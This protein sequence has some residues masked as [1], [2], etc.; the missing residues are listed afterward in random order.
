[1]QERKERGGRT[2]A[3]TSLAIG[4]G[5]ST[6]RRCGFSSFV[7]NRLLVRCGR[8]AETVEKFVELAH[9]GAAGR[10]LRCGRLRFSLPFLR[11]C[12]LG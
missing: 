12:W 2:L 4:G 9:G 7:F 11:L 3:E 5:Y 8:G 6:L 10:R 1:V